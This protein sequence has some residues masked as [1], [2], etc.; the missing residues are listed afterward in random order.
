MPMHS[1]RILVLLLCK[2]TGLDFRVYT[3][4]YLYSDRV[5]DLGAGRKRG[6]WAWRG[7][8]LE[9]ARQKDWGDAQHHVTGYRGRPA[10]E[11]R[12][13]TRNTRLFR[14]PISCDV[15]NGMA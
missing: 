1:D 7:Q 9:E 3:K 15:I 6:G 8:V 11:R 4:P 13:C 2:D 10:Q 5:F 14:P 12:H